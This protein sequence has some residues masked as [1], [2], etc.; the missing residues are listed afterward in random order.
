[1]IKPAKQAP[2][3]SATAM[4][5]ERLLSPVGPGP[6]VDNWKIGNRFT[7]C[8]TVMR[9]DGS[10]LRVYVAGA[11]SVAAAELGVLAAVKSLS[12]AL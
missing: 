12:G 1:M 5:I 3:K 8:G 4:E 9:S 10:V 6:S 2:E 7:S 11:V